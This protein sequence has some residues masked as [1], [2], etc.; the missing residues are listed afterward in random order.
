[1]NVEAAQKAGV[2][3]VEKGDALTVLRQ[4]RGA[5]DTIIAIDFLEHFR[6]DEL[7]PLLDLIRDAVDPAS[8]HIVLAGI[9][10]SKGQHAISFGTTRV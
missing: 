2:R 7:F 3:G 5:F 1:M 9:Q 6:K 8:G 10:V 4:S